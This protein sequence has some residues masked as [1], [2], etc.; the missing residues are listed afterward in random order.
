MLPAV[1]RV[2]AVRPEA[3]LVHTLEI[4]LTDGAVWPGFSPGQFTML[5]V[6]GVG[7]VPVSLS[8]PPGDD[9][10]IVH[11]V[12]AV[13]PV[14]EALA[15]LQ[16]GD[17][18]G[19]R[20]PYGNGWPVERAAGR[21]VLVIAGGLGLAPVRPIL[22]RLAAD[23]AR[24]G[25]A[26]LLY[27][28]RGPADLLFADEYPAWREAGIDVAATVDH[29]GADWRGHVGLV[30]L[31]I[32]KAAFEPANAVAFVCGPEV[33]MRFAAKALLRAGMADSDI[34]V[35]LERNMKCGVGLCGHCQLGPLVVCRDGPVFDYGRA[36]PLL[37][38][39]EL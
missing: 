21:D 5:S 9:R 14:S 22:Y 15:R 13:G 28:S 34:F 30:T 4:A 24:F 25:R 31:L 17:R 12:R 29:A 16:P 19:L 38:T 26:A 8:G 23:R 3:P 32:D 1:A 27:G 18:L 37:A 33:M 10:R 11:T 39:K 20:G 36:G 7:E 35:S 6:F 2:T